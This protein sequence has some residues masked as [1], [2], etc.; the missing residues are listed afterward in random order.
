M[1]I[2]GEAQVTGSLLPKATEDQLL[3]VGLLCR[4]TKHRKKPWVSSENKLSI[5]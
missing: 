1:A 4:E 3:R 2:I 5:E